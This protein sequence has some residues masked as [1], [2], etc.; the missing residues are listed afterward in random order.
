MTKKGIITD[1]LGVEPVR[2]V[3]LDYNARAIIMERSHFAAME[4]SE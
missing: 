3:I 1:F 2:D 4:Y